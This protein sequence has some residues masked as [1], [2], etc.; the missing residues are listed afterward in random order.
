MNSEA[1]L[2]FYHL[3]VMASLLH[4][5]VG[6]QDELIALIAAQNCLGFLALASYIVGIRL[7]T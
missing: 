5:N 6:K 3:H 1:R 2:F 4:D 7:F